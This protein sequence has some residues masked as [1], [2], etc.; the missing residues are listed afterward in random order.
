MAGILFNSDNSFVFCDHRDPIKYHWN[1]NYRST[2]GNFQ[3]HVGL[4]SSFRCRGYLHLGAIAWAS[5][6][7]LI[8]NDLKSK[9]TF[10]ISLS[11]L[12]FLFN[13]KISK[14]TSFWLYKTFQMTHHTIWYRIKTIVV[15][16]LA[17]SRPSL[18]FVSYLYSSTS[19]GKDESIDT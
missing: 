4:M 7:M 1:F 11:F 6:S 5:G 15:P 19:H 2:R 8:N 9:K 14:Q 16:L 17:T 13:C 18:F 12:S 3:R 10:L